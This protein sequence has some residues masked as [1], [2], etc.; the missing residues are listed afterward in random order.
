MAKKPFDINKMASAARA[1]AARRRTQGANRDSRVK[2]GGKR[3]TSKDRGFQ[4]VAGSQ[5]SIAQR[6]AQRSSGG[7][8]ALDFADRARRDSPAE[9]ATSGGAPLE[10]TRTDHHL[11]YKLDGRRLETGD[12]IEVFTNANSGW[13]RGRFEWNGSGR[14]RPR[15]GL[16]LWNP[17][18]PFAE[19]RAPW[20]GDL[21]ASLPE[22]AICRWA[23]E[24]S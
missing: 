11:R 21:F 15:L 3:D 13:L 5:G 2:V 8:D 17:N 6:L 24:S 7:N 22:A 16:N 14:D 10:L 12:V 1:N 20:C 4:G 9:G 19:D 18:G 23:E